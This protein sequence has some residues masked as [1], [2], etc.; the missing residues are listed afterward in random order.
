MRNI[1]TGTPIGDV[2]R[3]IRGGKLISAELTKTPTDENG[4]LTARIVFM[5]EAAARRYLTYRSQH[6]LLLSTLTELQ[7]G[8]P[9]VAARVHIAMLATR[10]S[11]LNQRY[12]MEIIE[13][14]ATRCLLILN[15]P[16][17]LSMSHIYAEFSD[18]SHGDIHGIESTHQQQSSRNRLQ[19]FVTFTSVDRAAY[20]KARINNFRVF[21]SAMAFYVPDECAGAVEDLHKIEGTVPVGELGTCG[22]SWKPGSAGCAKGNRKCA[23]A[24]S[25]VQ[26]SRF[27]EELHEDKPWDPGVQGLGCGREEKAAI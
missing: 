23:E 8:H 2:T 11:Q 4:K 17:H 3:R 10:T 19:I 18:P 27:L 20:A 6:P 16:S 13:R 15:F 9:P 1:P 21:G 5:H 12:L 14:G 24:E 25:T 26:S 22:A 7:E